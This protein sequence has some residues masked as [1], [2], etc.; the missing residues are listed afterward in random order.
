MDGTRIDKVEMKITQKDGTETFYRSL[1][2]AL[3]KSEEILVQ[4]AHVS[5]GE[6]HQGSLIVSLHPETSDTATQLRQFIEN[7]DMSLFLAQLFKAVDLQK[8]FTNNEPTIEIQINRVGS[9]G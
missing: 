8:L 6:V 3:P 5:I 4:Y 7:G 9:T 1:I 2:S